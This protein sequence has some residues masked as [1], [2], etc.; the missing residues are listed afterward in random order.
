MEKILVVDDE[1]GLVDI[2]T[3]VLTDDGYDVTGITDSVEAVELIR[4][5]HFDLV[6]TDLKMPKVDGIEI[7]R[8]VKDKSESTDVVVIT[9]Y[10]S[11]ETAVE[12]LK[13]NVYDYILKPFNINDISN[14]VKRVL[15]R[16]RLVRQNEKLREKIEKNLNDITTLYEISKIMTYTSDIEKIVSFAAETIQ[17]SID[18][19][20]FS[21]MLYSNDTKKY[22]IERAVGL[23]DN[24]IENFSFELNRGIIGNSLKER[25]IVFVKDFENDES[26][27]SFVDDEDKKKIIS[28]V[29]IPLVVGENL[30]G[31]ITVHSVK[32]ENVDDMDK[33][34]L[35]S[36]VST[37]ISPLIN[38]FLYQKEQEI[39]YEDPLFLVKRQMESIVNKAAV[40]KGGMIFIVFR[41]YLKRFGESADKIIK[42]HQ[43]IL[44]RL[45]E[46]I[47]IIDSVIVLGLE[48]F[49]VILQG[50]SQVAAQIFVTDVKD[51]IEK[52]ILGN[53]SGFLIDHGYSSYP[54]DGETAE[55]LIGKAQSN[56]WRSI[57]SG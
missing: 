16:Q 48:S 5:N 53:D 39:R 56:L 24:T 49:V 22:T 33:L 51:E 2:I 20:V 45:R 21:I 10:G 14:T 36:I 54:I 44:S 52:N 6:I 12:S 23:S 15:E 40:Y 9:G 8:I 32:V 41:L 37:Q 19:D 1:Q 31:A 25:E 4:D 30:F 34:N 55:E 35:L 27:M 3:E 17:E 28:F 43:E 42:I 13:K 57:K 38:L 26:Y 50:R 11:M 46:S 7:T 47:S 18:I 29:I